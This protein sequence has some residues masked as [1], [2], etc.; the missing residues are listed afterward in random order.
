MDVVTS[1][2]GSRYFVTFIDDYSRYTT[3]Y[4]MK[5]KSEV[6][7]KFTEFVNLVENRTGL[8]VKRL[9]SIQL[10]NVYVLITVV[11]IRRPNSKVFV[12]TV[13]FRVNQPYR[14]PLNKTESPNV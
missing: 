11:N 5:H 3:V 4:M 14:I 13:E 8:K 12:P 7:A 9:N 6:L 1:V 2:G 10:F